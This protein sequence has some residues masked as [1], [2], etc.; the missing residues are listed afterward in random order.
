MASASGPLLHSVDPSP[1]PGSLVPGIR[2]TP[3]LPR[4]GSVKECEEDQFR[5]RNERC[6]PSV[7]RCDEDDDCSDNSDEDDCRE[8]P[9]GE[10]GKGGGL[11]AQRPRGCSRHR[12]TCLDL[13]CRSLQPGTLPGALSLQAL[14]DPAGSGPAGPDGAGG[15]ARRST[16][17]EEGTPRPGCWAGTVGRRRDGPCKRL[18][19]CDQALRDSCLGPTERTRVSKF[20]ATLGLA[21]LLFLLG[22]VNEWAPRGP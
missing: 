6:I 17:R 14:R 9:A 4:A 10:G 7:W 16:A 2:L 1:R 21:S 13:Y 15:E 18:A 5:C 22:F 8:W 19:F 11:L 3:P 12:A 20:Q